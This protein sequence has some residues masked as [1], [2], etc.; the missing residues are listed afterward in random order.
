MCRSFSTARSLSEG[1]IQDF[2]WS[3]LIIYRPFWMLNFLVMLLRTG[4]TLDMCVSCVFVSLDGGLPLAESHRWN[5]GCPPFLSAE[6]FDSIAFIHAHKA[7]TQLCCRS[8]ATV[9]CVAFLF[10]SVIAV[11]A[12]PTTWWHLCL[13]YPVS[14]RFRER[15]SNYYRMVTKAGN[16]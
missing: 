8:S 10:E 15:K 7:S 13:C 9:L 16:P 14:D 5:H 4:E 11:P 6:I 1:D 12:F 2:R 3:A